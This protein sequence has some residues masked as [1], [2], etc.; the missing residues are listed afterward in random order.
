MKKRLS[1]V[2]LAHGRDANRMLAR[3]LIYALLKNG[4]IKTT[5]AKARLVK[6]LWDR[7]AHRSKERTEANKN[8]LLKKLGKIELV[9]IFFKK[10]GP[11]I[12]ESGRGFIKMKKIGQRLSDGSLMVNL[13]WNF[14]LK[15]KRSKEKPSAKIEQKKTK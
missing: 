1:K 3:K 9:N 14:E 5:I 10:V 6:P 15:K 12:K 13:G 8:V 2:K 11:Q 7:L 4:Q